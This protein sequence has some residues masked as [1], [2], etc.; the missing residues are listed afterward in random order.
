[1]IQAHTFKYALLAIGFG[2]ALGACGGDPDPGTTTVTY[3]ANIQ[4]DMNSLSCL[5]TGC[6]NAT[7][8]TKLKIDTT[9]GKE[10]ANYDGLFSNNLVIKGDAANSPLIKIPSTG[11]TLGNPPVT[12]VKTL[13]GTKLTDWTNWVNAMA[14]F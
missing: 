8:T 4:K 3:S 1:M 10:Q 11:M 2:A 5:T 12:H 13:S 7:S 6:H 14:P 9:A